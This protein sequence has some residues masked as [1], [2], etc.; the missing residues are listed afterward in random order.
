MKINKHQY[1]R[2]VEPILSR[3]KN[4]QIE[5]ILIKWIHLS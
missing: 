3:I 1:D 4:D 2:N 5:N